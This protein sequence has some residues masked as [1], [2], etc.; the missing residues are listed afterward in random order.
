[1]N[2][3]FTPNYSKLEYDRR[4]LKEWDIYKKDK[5]PGII[6]LTVESWCFKICLCDFL[7]KKKKVNMEFWIK[8]AYDIFYD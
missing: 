7:A 3:I 8:V 5:L 1:M 6:D 4:I 2:K